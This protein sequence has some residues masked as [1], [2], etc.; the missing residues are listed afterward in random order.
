ML[1]GKVIL[2]R[3]EFILTRAAWTELC[4]VQNDMEREDEPPDG[5][6][7]ESFDS[8]V[9]QLA[10]GYGPPEPPP[11]GAGSEPPLWR[12]PHASVDWPGREASLVNYK[13][14]GDVN[15]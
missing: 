11:E 7:G 1:L 13:Q 3:I 9:V 15:T 12:A 8:A 10:L 14:T 6:T 4:V 2:R 5:G